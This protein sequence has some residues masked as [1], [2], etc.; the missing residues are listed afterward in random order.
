MVLKNPWKFR[1]LY[2]CLLLLLAPAWTM[3]QTCTSTADGGTL[4]GIINTYYTGSGT[5]AAGATSI[6]ITLASQRGSATTIAAGDMLLIMQMQD[7]DINSNNTGA[8][9]DGGGGNAGFGQTA[10]NSAGFFEYVVATAAP[11]GGGVIT[12]V[13]AGAGNGLLHSYRTAAATGAAGQRRFQVIR[14]P[15]FKTATLSSTL[16]AA[17]WDGNNGGVLAVDITSTLTLGGTVSVDGLGFRGGA[18]LRLTGN[19]GG[20]GDYRNAAPAAPPAGFHGSKGEGI[21]GTP[22]WIFDGTGNADTGVEG[23][24][25]G[26]M[27][28]GGPGNAGGGGTDGTPG[29]GN[30]ENSGGGGGG[31]GGQGGI[32]GNTWNSNSAT[33]GRP[34]A[35]FPFVTGANA[36]IMMGGG[37][38]AGTR[39]NSDA[40][41]VASAGGLGGGIV[42]I[43]ASQVTGTGTITAN[44]R[45]RDIAGIEPLNDGGGG[46]GA[47]GTVVVTTRTGTLTGL[48]VQAHGGDGVNAWPTQPPG[49]TPGERHGPGGGGGGG[50]ILLSSAA[51]STNVAGGVNGTTT[52]AA[53]AYGAT[54]GATGQSSTTVTMNNI[55]GVQS[56]NSLTRA[57]LQGLK[58]DPHGYVEFATGSQQGS[59][60]FHIW[61]T[62]DPMGARERKRITEAPVASAAVF[63]LE[64]LVYRTQTQPITDSYL[65][66]EEIGIGGKHR[67]MGPFP[68][69]DTR[70]KEEFEAVEAQVRDRAAPRTQPTMQPVVPVI[71]R[72]SGSGSGALK[73]Q[74]S[75]AGIV[76]VSAADLTAAG[77]PAGLLAQP[78]KLRLTNLGNPVPFEILPAGGPPDSIQFV[79][80][81]LTTDYTN[82]NV[83]VLSW[84][85]KA[86]PAPAVSLT[87]S[88]LA[89]N[90]GMVRIEHNNFYAPFVGA[91]SD[92]WIWDWIFTPGPSVTISFDVPDLVPQSSGMV[93][94]RIAFSGGY[95]HQHTVKATLNGQ[96]V[97][98]IVFNGKTE[99]AITGTVPYSSI[100]ATGNQLIVEY[101]AD[102]QNP[103]DFSAVFLDSVDLGVNV[104]PVLGSVTADL[105]APFDFDL[106]KVKGVDY[107]I[108][109]HRSFVGGAGQIADSK[110]LDGLNPL[111]VDVDAA[112]NRY[113]GGV[114]EAR[115]IQKLIQSLKKKAGRSLKYVLLVGD[116]TFDPNNYL[117]YGLMSF[118]PSINGMD[119]DFGRVPSENKYADVDGDGAPEVAIGR[120]P[121]STVAEMDAL[122]GKIVLQ[123]SLL[124]PGLGRMLFAADNQ[125]DADTDFMKWAEDDSAFVPA[126]S[127]IQWADVSDGAPAARSALLN[128][129]STGVEAT[130]MFGH[131]NNTTWTDEGIL[132]SSDAGSLEESGVA[133][134]LFSWACE[135]GWYQYHL[136]KS[137][138]EA[139]VLVP[140]GGAVA[141]FGPSGITEPGTQRTFSYSLYSSL[142]SGMSIGQAVQKT[143]ME[144]AKNGKDSGLLLE[145]WN[146]L[147]DPALN[148]NW[149]RALTIKETR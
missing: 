89:L 74:V 142:R 54:A 71:R 139:L 62:P 114:V 118:L 129:L 45:G 46:G 141:A 16:T 124:Q 106:P 19:G 75:A 56:C 12:I 53:D 135:V 117:G 133:T 96:L 87:R 31:N 120:L 72:A 25:N 36:R 84:T 37:G 5:V 90:P 51:T 2:L 121:V 13:G 149:N 147:G 67:M 103:D 17:A 111:V 101:S 57:T 130:N 144:L 41:T 63:S 93:D 113:S 52:T 44:G 140:N 99:E 50:V 77:M 3:A 68:V 35:L 42:L 126:G 6:T 18:G 69:G 15:V 64:P 30:T 20:A 119:E 127:T 143:R 1:L 83:Y 116:D 9:G 32:G 137:L 86:P 60:A 39:N 100:L 123:N 134:V 48:T 7:A 110:R 76:Q 148:L 81:K 125:G 78:Q 79:S 10:L 136:S 94:V 22:R 95:D 104:N 26:S 146:L 85:K 122:A 29:A 14:V 128:A 115:A 40:I 107:L 109:T 47:G 21:A 66:I 33:G 59:L 58:V 49:G 97:G 24:P 23:Y 8:Y 55:P 4:T 108:L 82:H 98:Q 138:D 28:R 112:Y 131:G 43:R 105:V 73:I 11:T 88:G 61:Q 38:G 132:S 70:L 34:G 92:P 91:D 80:S 145:G 65:L 27:A 102:L